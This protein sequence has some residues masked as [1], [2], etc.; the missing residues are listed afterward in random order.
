V[1]ACARAPSLAV[2]G[3]RRAYHLR[4]PA[5]ARA[6]APS[7]TVAGVSTSAW[8]L[9][10]SRRR[11]RVRMIPTSLTPA[12]VCGTSLTTASVRAGSL[13]VVNAVRGAWTCDGSG[14]VQRH[15]RSHVG[16]GVG[17]LHVAAVEQIVSLDSAPAKKKDEGLLTIREKKYPRRRLL[18]GHGQRSSS[19]WVTV[20]G[21]LH[22]RQRIQ[23][24]LTRRR[25]LTLMIVAV[26]DKREAVT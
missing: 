2:A 8:A 16:G 26:A 24:K 13:A 14:P 11:Q 3:V 15:R 20:S 22:T 12:S 25:E 6:R 23:K 7:L 10:R 9:P 21:L 19:P 18:Q 17:L 1:S 4:S 5:S